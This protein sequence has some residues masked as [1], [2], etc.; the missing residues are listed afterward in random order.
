MRG[1]PTSGERPIVSGG[2]PGDSVKERRSFPIRRTSASSAMVLPAKRLPAESSPAR[3]L[4]LTAQLVCGMS[5]EVIP[6]EV[7]PV[8]REGSQP[9]S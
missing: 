2:P 3:Q 5:R 8:E 9:T 1:K 7:Q 6:S 4:A